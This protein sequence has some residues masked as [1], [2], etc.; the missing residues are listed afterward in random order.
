MQYPRF[1]AFS[2][3][4]LVAAVPV[5]RAADTAPIIQ[6]TQ[7]RVTEDTLQPGQSKTLSDSRPSVIVCFEGDRVSIG[8]KKDRLDRGEAVFL[9]AE[10]R[11]IRN[12]GSRPL[13][14]VRVA[15]LDAGSSEVWGMDG[16]PPSYKILLENRYTRVYNISIPAHSYGPRH[17]QH[18]R[19]V[20][21]L[22][23]AELQEI[24]PDGQRQPSTLK[25]GEIVW[26]A[27]STHVGHNI[28]DTNLWVIIVEPK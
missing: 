25:T 3:L 18:G 26:H 20:M 2:A 7:V 14:F 21:V 11:H 22:S 24:L 6:N 4:A 27:A 8:L 16:L 15:F 23:G 13:H 10:T 5:S 9:S 1:L 28:G 12:S 17:T 19:V